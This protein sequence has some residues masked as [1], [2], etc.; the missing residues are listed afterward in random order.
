MKIVTGST[1][2]WLTAP[3]MVSFINKVVIELETKNKE[4]K[5]TFE[6]FQCLKPSKWLRMKKDNGD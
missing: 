3:E 1:L 4:E 2:V 6:Q 5:E